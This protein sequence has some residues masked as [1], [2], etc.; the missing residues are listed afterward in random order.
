ME[1]IDGD[2]EVTA[3]IE[4]IKAPGH[5]PGGIVVVVSSGDERLVSTF[6]LIHQPSDLAWPTLY[7]VFDA[8]PEL[9]SRTRQ[10]IFSHFMPSSPLVFACHFPFPGLGYIVPKGNA[11]LWKPSGLE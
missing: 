8:N 3:G 2:A 11:W 9:G 10:Q 6:D 1:L 5:T 7:S 4:V